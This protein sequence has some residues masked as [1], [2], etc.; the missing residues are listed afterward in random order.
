MDRELPP[1]VGRLWAARADVAVAGLAGAAG[2]AGSYAAAG[3]TPSFV[4]APVEGVIARYVPG[5]LVTFAITV[6]GDLGQQLSLLTA[7]ALSA[8]LLAAFAGGGLLAG[9]RLNSR[10][11]G[12]LLAGTAAWLATALATGSL[13]LAVG[14]GLP[15]ALVLA[16]VEL[17]WRGSPSASPDRER[18]RA[19]TGLL[20][21]LSLSAVGVALGRERTPDAT[22]LDRSGSAID[23]STERGRLLATARDRSFDL[24]GADP[25]VSREFYSVDINSVDPTVDAEAWTL[26]VTGAVEEE[27]EFDLAALR[28]RPVENRFATLRCVGEDLNGE[29]MDTALW[30][31]TPLRGIVEAAGPTGDCDCVM[32][33]G[34]D[35][36]SVQFPVEALRD[37]LLAWGMNAGPLPRAHGYPVRALVPGHWGETNAKWITEMEFLE[38]EA[39]G[40]WEQ[41]GWHGTGPVETV[42]KLHSVDRS[43]GSVQVGGHAYAGTRGVSAVE[44]STDGG[45]TWAEAELTDPLPG[46]GERERALDA[47]RAWRHRYDD[48]GSHTV[49]VRAVEADG[50]VQPREETD[51]YPSGPSG[52]VTRRLG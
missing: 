11:A 19:L 12:P 35:G 1:P 30:T 51:S 32:L 52:W 8:A 9:R 41:K 37:G 2:V 22:A 49:V 26:S 48:P 31:G 50:T 6:L 36:Y 40:Y 7:L 4:A 24:P 39:D 10:A 29:K 17:P 44:V 14:G 43:A 5:A 3:F 13:V 33:H 46:W 23:T 16:A 21:A 34:V 38:Q 15:V 28:D 45:E 47:W 25:L 42:A 18:R 20:S 27:L